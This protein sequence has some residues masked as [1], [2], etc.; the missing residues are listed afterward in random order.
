MGR[1]PKPTTI[2]KPITNNIYTDEQ[3]NQHPILFTPHSGAQ[4]QFLTNNADIVLFASCVGAGKSLCLLVDAAKYV[5]KYPHFNALLLRRTYPELER[6]LIKE[7]KRLYS[8]KLNGQYHETKHLWTFPSGARIQFGSLDN[9]NDITSYRGI[10]WTYLGFDELT[11]FKWDHV[12]ML[13]AWNRTSKEKPVPLRFRATS[14]PGGV[15]HSEVFEYWHRWLD[16]DHPQHLKSNTIL[17]TKD[18]KTISC[19]MAYMG[20]N[21]SIDEIEYKKQF[22]GFPEHIIDQLLNNDWKARPSE[23]L[24][25]KRQLIPILPA[26][27]PNTTRSV[28]AYDLASSTGKNADYTASVKISRLDNGK[29]SV[30]DVKRAKLGPDEVEQLIL[31][32]AKA[33]GRGVKIVLPLEPGAA[34]KAWANHLGRALA[35]YVFAFVPQTRSSGSKA[36]RAQPVSSQALSGNL[37]LVAGPY[38][39]DFLDE[40]EAFTDNPKDYAHDDM[41][42]ALALGFNELCHARA[43]FRDIGIKNIGRV[44]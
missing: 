26:I 16:P 29:Y 21:P 40:L 30:G 10:D 2:P 7:S 25:F 36:V 13:R 20:D 3:G 42:D 1:K 9:D 39:K 19:V 32:T 23:C 35:G 38:T 6:S 11:T 37:S 24:Y 5:E 12:Q 22:T 27:P 28:R 4:T 33:D 34:G 43:T 31:K 14:N 8:G 44:I 18:G 41:V 17:K 15:S